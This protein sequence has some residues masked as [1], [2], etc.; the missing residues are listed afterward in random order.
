MHS[1]EIKAVFT[2]KIVEFE[3]LLCLD[4]DSSVIVARHFNFR[5]DELHQWFDQADSLKY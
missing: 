3:E 4:F 5:A 2:A 1:S